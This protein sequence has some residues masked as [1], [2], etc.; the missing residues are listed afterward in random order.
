MC[1]FGY[2]SRLPYLVELTGL[3]QYSLARQPLAARGPIGHEKVADDAWLRRN[4][5]QLVVSQDFPPVAA[6]AVPRSDEILF[7]DLAR[8]RI[9]TWDD[10][11]MDALRG[12]PGVEFVPIERTLAAAAREMEA[13]TPERA[14]EIYAGLDAWYFSAAG[15]RGEERAR[16][17]RAILERRERAAD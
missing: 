8:A 13:A 11:L 17:L 14:R 2:Y 16:P 6:P 3:T 4:G 9:V 7:G 1:V 15:A 5:V 10:A 12:R